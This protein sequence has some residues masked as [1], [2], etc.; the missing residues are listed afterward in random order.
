MNDGPILVLKFYHISNESDC[1]YDC[2]SVYI[3]EN[4]NACESLV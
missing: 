4:L 1:S 3:L 2:I